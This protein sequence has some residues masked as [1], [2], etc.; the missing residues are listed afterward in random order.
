MPRYF[1]LAFSL[2]FSAHLLAS[3]DLPRYP[4]ATLESDDSYD[5]TTSLTL[6]TDD[7]LDKVLAFYRA[8]PHVTNCKAPAD[9]PESYTCTYADGKR[10]GLISPERKSYGVTKIDITVMN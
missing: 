9:Y 8:Q 1:A 10:R 2:L 3:D 4:G 5:G 7:E 6:A